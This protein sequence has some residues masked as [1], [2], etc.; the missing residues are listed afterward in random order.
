[1]T[2]LAIFVDV[3]DDAVDPTLVD[4][5]EIGEEVVDLYNDHA[6]VAH[7]RAEITFVAAEWET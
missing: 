5:H 6:E 1:V 4:P 7:D 2:R 3:P